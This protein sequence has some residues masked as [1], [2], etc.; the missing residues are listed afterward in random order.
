MVGAIRVCRTKAKEEGEGSLTCSLVVG[1]VKRQTS[2]IVWVDFP[3]LSRDV[4]FQYII[5]QDH[6]SKSHW[7]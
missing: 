1:L 3:E 5:G 4:F 7:L 6:S 2:L